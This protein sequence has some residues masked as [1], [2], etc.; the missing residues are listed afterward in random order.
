MGLKDIR[1]FIGEDEHEL[2]MDA[3]RRRAERELGDASWAEVI[4]RAY[5]Y[6]RSD[7]DSLREKAPQLREP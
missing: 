3:A 6:P 2:R 4:V 5:L 1:G 7:T